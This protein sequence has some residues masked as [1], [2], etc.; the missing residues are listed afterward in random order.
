MTISP[1]SPAPTPVSIIL[2]RSP[3]RRKETTRYVVKKIS[4]VPKSPIIARQPRQNSE[5]AA[6]IIVLFF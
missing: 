2:D 6:Y 4:A 3:L 5:K 1:M